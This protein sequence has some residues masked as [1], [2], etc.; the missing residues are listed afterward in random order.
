MRKT[1]K[2]NKEEIV[3]RLSKIE[4]VRAID[5][6]IPD[7]IQPGEEEYIDILWK[8]GIGGN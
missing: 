8:P 6:T 4:G 7:E 2:I 5:M 3:R 1:F